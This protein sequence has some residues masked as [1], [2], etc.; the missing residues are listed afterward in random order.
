MEGYVAI[1]KTERNGFK[2][3]SHIENLSKEERKE[4][5][6]KLLHDTFKVL[7]DILHKKNKDKE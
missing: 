4:K 6:A 1:K 5:D 7:Y 3:T 2:V